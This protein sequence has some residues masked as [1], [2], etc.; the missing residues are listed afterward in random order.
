MVCMNT[1]MLPKHNDPVQDCENIL[2]LSGGSVLESVR[3]A[4]VKTGHIYGHIA[5]FIVLGQA[6]FA[7]ACPTYLQQLI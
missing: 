4:V 7:S 3:V 1:V 2:L 6:T 5:N